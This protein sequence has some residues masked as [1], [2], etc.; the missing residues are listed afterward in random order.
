MRKTCLDC[1]RK[2]VGAA[3]VTM[4]ET[5]MGYPQHACL[6]EGHLD[7]AA[8]EA[9]KDLPVLAMTLRTFRR[10]WS[11]AFNQYLLG[12]TAFFPSVENLMEDLHNTRITI[13]AQTTNEEATIEE[14]PTVPSA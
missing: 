2:H 5:Y 6:V 1:I 11:S 13:L 9:V 8:A 4:D 7:Q 12:Y 10:E 14:K 3:L